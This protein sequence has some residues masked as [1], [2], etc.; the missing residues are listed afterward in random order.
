MTRLI[1]S[2]DIHLD[3][4]EQD[5]LN[6]F[7]ESIRESGADLLVLSGDISGGSTLS[8]WL[9]RIE[10]ELAIPVRFVLGNHDFYSSSFQ[11]THEV[12]R[13]VVN[14]TSKT[15]NGSRKLVWLSDG[16]IEAVSEETALIGHDGWYDGRAGIIGS[17]VLND[18]MCIEDLKSAL[19]MSITTFQ[20]KLKETA[21][22][23]ASYIKTTLEK[24]FVLRNK[25]VMA[26]HI[27]PFPQAALHRGA[28]TNVNFLPY[29]CCVSM[30]RVLV[31]I[32]DNNK[33]KELIVLCGHTHGKCE[34]NIL[35]N[36]KVLV[37]GAEYGYPKLCGM[38]EI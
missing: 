11:K 9:N 19:M 33:D 7:F 4:A 34:I 32:M 21:D 10:S 13:E 14:K 15:F 8:K 1:W 18:F 38:M 20:Y 37:A 12:V 2:S 24:A 3:H 5:E 29:Y 28:P 36:L 26:T 25:V 27:S 31:D 22:R 30:G 17:A 23:A 6:I 16:I 35:P